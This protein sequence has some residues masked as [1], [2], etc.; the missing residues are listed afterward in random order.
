L[1]AALE[2]AWVGLGFAG[3]VADEAFRLEVLARV[4]EPTSKHD[5]LRV[6]GGLGVGWVPAYRTVKQCLVRCQE[7][8]YRARLEAACAA[9][10]DVS[11]I[12]FCLYDVTTLY[13]ETDTADEFRKPGYSKERR[14]EPQITVG[15]LT[16]PNGFPLMIR[17]FEGNKAETKT[18]IPVLDQFR[19][20]HPGVG[21]TVVADA[22]MMSEANLIGLEQAGYR[23]II[24][25]RIPDV[26]GAVTL[27][28]QAHPG[29][30]LSD[31]QLFVSRRPASKWHARDW[32][33]FY[34]YRADRAKRNQ[35]GIDESVRK[36]QKIIDGLASAKRNRFLKESGGS[37]AIDQELVES[38]R[39]RAGIRSYMTNLD[40]P[41]AAQV[42]A[43]YHQLWHVENSFRMS[44][45]DLRARP[46]YHRLRERIE[47]HLTIVF[48]A[49]AIGRWIETV[50]G[51]S[52]RVFLHTLR[53]IRQVTL[54]IGGTDVVGEDPLTDT[55]TTILNAITKATGH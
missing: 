43:T 28:R 2:S 41:D 39:L 15:L 20:A 12:V 7:R 45:H 50:T 14:L 27:W 53:P 52:L 5:S 17:A 36:A 21:V 10:V 13:W 46:A 47:A 54:T 1:I 9:W 26:P 38:A 4:V 32:T 3:A 30:D 35:H 29:E 19:A 22:G 51:V 18:I 23:F 44:K 8:G 40:D 24:G 11:S 48:A 42:I 6:L 49:L 34:Q 37:L 31:G 16:D 33:V 55:A 25:G